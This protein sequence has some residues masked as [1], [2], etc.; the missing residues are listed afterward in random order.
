MDYKSL[1]GILTVFRNKKIINEN[2]LLANVYI[3]LYLCNNNF[4]VTKYVFCRELN[5]IPHLGIMERNWPKCVLQIICRHT[6][7]NELL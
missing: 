5:K 3:V 7:T 2:F 4:L 6:L 1:L